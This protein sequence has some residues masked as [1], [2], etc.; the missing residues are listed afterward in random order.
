MIIKIPGRRA[1]TVYSDTNTYIEI[2]GDGP[3]EVVE[4]ATSGPIIP[5]QAWVSTVGGSDYWV[6]TVGGTDYWVSSS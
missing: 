6:S 1:V 4:A 5:D 3:I 2:P